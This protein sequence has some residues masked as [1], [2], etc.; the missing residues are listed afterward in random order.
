MDALGSQS[1]PVRHSMLKCDSCRRRKQKV[2]DQQ[3]SESAT[4]IDKQPFADNARPY[5]ASLPTAN[6]RKSA[7]AANQTIGSGASNYL[8]NLQVLLSSGLRHVHLID[9]DHPQFSKPTERTSPSR[10]Q[11]D[12]ACRPYNR[13]PGGLRGYKQSGAQP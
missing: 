2:S 11:E 6:G 3:P 7:T 9:S 8:S 1:Q 12:N 5:S 13:V 10:T 4:I